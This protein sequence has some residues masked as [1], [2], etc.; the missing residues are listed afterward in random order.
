MVA[1]HLRVAVLAFSALTWTGAASAQVFQTDAAKT[2]LPQPVAQK[3][4][5]L[6][7][8]W[9]FLPDVQVNRDATGADINQQNKHYSDFFPTF[10]G[11]AETNDA[12]TLQGL[13]KFRGEKLDPVANARTAPGHFSPSCGFSGQLL[14]R[15]GNCEI[16]FG[17]YNVEDPN[18]TTP[19]KPEEVYPFLP[20]EV[21]CLAPRPCTTP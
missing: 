12:I 7:R 14:L 11:T 18:S 4:L 1:R 20:E 21:C 6:P 3:E 17:W 15:G 2:P 9:G 13:F 10:E 8:S 19:P 16:T 5:D